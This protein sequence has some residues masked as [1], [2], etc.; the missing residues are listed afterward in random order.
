MYCAS[1]VLRFNWYRYRFPVQ[2]PQ[3]DGPAPID[4]PSN[5]NATKSVPFIDP[6]DNNF[7]RSIR[8]SMTRPDVPDDQ[9]VTNWHVCSESSINRGDLKPWTAYAPYNSFRFRPYNEFDKKGRE[10][11]A[12]LRGHARWSVDP[13]SGAPLREA[14]LSRMN[15]SAVR[16]NAP[17]LSTVMERTIQESCAHLPV[18]SPLMQNRDVGRIELPHPAAALSHPEDDVFPFAWRTEDWYEYEIANVRL[19]RFAMANTDSTE[20]T[21]RIVLEALWEH[22]AERLADDVSRFVSEVA[23][24]IVEEKLTSVRAS[25]ASLESAALDGEIIAAFGK[26]RQ[27]FHANWV[28]YSDDEI[29]Q[30]MLRELRDIEAACAD[31][32]NKC[33][34]AGPRGADPSTSWPVVEKM[35]PW[36]RM[37]EYWSSSAD[38]TFREMEESTKHYEFR[39][40]YRVIVAKLP[41][42]STEFERRM[43][44]IRHWLHRST[45]AEFHTVYRKNLVHDLTEFPVEHD[46]AQRTTAQHHQL[47]SFALDWGTAPADFAH[48]TRCAKG[49]T[50]E[51]VAQRLGCTVAA[52]KASNPSVVDLA[53]AEKLTIPSSAVRRTVVSV[54]A[55]IP[56]SAALCSWEAVAAHVGCTVEEL[57]ELNPR[58][59]AQYQ[60]GK[61]GAETTELHVPQNDTGAFAATEAVYPSDTFET[62]AARLGTSVADLKATNSTVQS[63]GSVSVVT[64]PATATRPRRL[65]DPKLLSPG[66]TEALFSNS[67]SEAVEFGLPGEIP[68]L[69]ANASKFPHEYHQRG[70]KYPAVPAEQQHTETWAQY[71][72]RYLDTELQANLAEA[73]KADFNV[74]PVWPYQQVPGKD[75]RAPFSEDQTWFLQHTPI[76]QKPL[77]HPD[78]YI[79]DVPLA[80]HEQF[81]RSMEWQA[82]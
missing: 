20:V 58:A 26:S 29:K 24:Q 67:I 5:M 79:Q 34:V 2:A 62:I 68:T 65:H 78:G 28:N 16:A 42:Q 51:S 69:P 4:A 25:I 54:P 23:K 71:T 81:A 61:F 55:T 31:V 74:N 37:A 30:F 18:K 40:Y 21:Y 12:K 33:N 36:V 22:H 6:V 10:Y 53:A 66:A 49:D 50:W 75:D 64:V 45:T 14:Y 80:N 59:M 7:P 39:R 52:L 43:Y 60:G 3:M 11:V 46:P 48:E 73:P 57:Q 44:D 70:H 1:R 32:I 41:F 9:Y 56:T 35:E 77:A 72:A 63:L 82:P 19:K 38:R 47:L 15:P 17:T 13:S 76:Q 8:G 27:P